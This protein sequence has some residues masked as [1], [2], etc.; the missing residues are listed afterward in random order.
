MGVE[1]KGERGG[2]EVG[3]G[4]V[5]REER[6]ENGKGK[7]VGVIAS[8]VREKGVDVVV[9][10]LG[11]GSE[12]FIE[13]LVGKGRGE[14]QGEGGKRGGVDEEMRWLKVVETGSVRW[15]LE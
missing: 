12:G 6:G 5:V 3:G 1:G 13:G 7:T 2:V 4:G 9:A 8:R 14:K 15:G 10:G 11:D